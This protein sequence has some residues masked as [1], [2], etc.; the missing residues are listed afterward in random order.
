[1]DSDIPLTYTYVCL[2]TH[3]ARALRENKIWTSVNM[4]DKQNSTISLTLT[5]ADVRKMV[6]RREC[7]PIDQGENMEC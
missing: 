6:M 1:M 7:T 4:F 5:L 3:L 2:A